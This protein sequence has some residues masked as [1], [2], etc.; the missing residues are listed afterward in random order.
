M[1]ESAAI[2]GVGCVSGLGWSVREFRD[3]LLSGRV[4]IGPF[5]LFDSGRHRTRVAAQVPVPASPHLILAP[6]HSRVDGFAVH[7]ARAAL[8][9]AG[10]GTAFD[11]DRIGVFFG[12][13]TAGMHETERFYARL[14]AHDARLRVRPVAA[15]QSNAPGDT[16]ART[17]GVRGPVVSVSTACVSAAQ[18][19]LVALDAIRSGEV[20]VAIAGGADGLCQLT[21]A[22]FNALRAV[23]AAA[24]VPYRA[25][26]Q[27]LSLGEGAGVLVLESSEHAKR[28]GAHVLGW[29][30]GAGSTCD[31]HH[32]A[33]PAPD[34]EGAARAIREA[35]QDAHLAPAE[36]AFVN[37]HGTG[38]PLNDSAE[39]MA[40]Q[41]VFGTRTRLLPVTSTKS[42]VGHLLGA[43]GALE[44]IATLLCLQAESVHPTAGPGSADPDL[45]VDLVLGTARPAPGA[46]FAVSTNL[47]F[48]GANTALVLGR[49]TP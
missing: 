49:T 7:A 33:A 43:A 27:G 32:V 30:L 13:S 14:T 5:D 48:G 22:G 21:Y 36:I 8:A 39:A 25:T 6:W 11:A 40:L 17:F 9:E 15:Q 28:R 42:L 31:A 34:G 41:S 26:R 18:A 38:T 2:S 16:V 23:D 37:V 12:T 1:G 44:A 19:L 35:L 47:A 45:G 24:C 46:R 29:L 20:D 3:G 10:L 4:A